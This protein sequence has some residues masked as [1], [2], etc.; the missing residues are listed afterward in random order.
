VSRFFEQFNGLHPMMSP[1]EG[2]AEGDVIEKVDPDPGAAVEPDAGGGEGDKGAAAKAGDQPSGEFPDNWRELM[3]G[4]DEEL[5]KQLQRTTDPKKLG[6]RFKDLY[7]KVR[8][9]VH[10]TDEVAPPKDEEALKEWRK[11]RG[12]PEDATGYEIP[13][14]IQKVMTEADKPI[15]AD[16]MEFMHGKNWTPDKVAEGLEWY[17]SFQQKIAEDRAAA[18]NDARETLEETLREEWGAD[19]KPNMQLAARVSGAN[20]EHNWLDARYADGTRIGDDPE[21]VRA[22]A[23]LGRTKFGDVAFSTEESAR[24][25]GDRRAEIEEIRKNDPD[26]YYDPK[27]GL[28]D[29]MFKIIQAEEKRG[30]R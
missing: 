1:D 14:E 17:A 4:D 3:A 26:K 10:E 16:F 15:A 21:V 6:T 23:D 29:E 24:K 8:A 7:A 22:L 12:I 5:L 28:Q 30:S 9:G 18:D 20:A 13:E 11:E 2:G 27:S 19:F 25:I